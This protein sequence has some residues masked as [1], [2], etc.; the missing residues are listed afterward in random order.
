MERKQIKTG[1]IITVNY[2]EMLGKSI[3]W[4]ERKIISELRKFAK[5][6]GW[7]DYEIIRDA[8]TSGKAKFIYRVKEAKDDPSRS[9]QN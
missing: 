1:L 6:S 3:D 5:S 4:V 9:E 2:E 8:K 7:K